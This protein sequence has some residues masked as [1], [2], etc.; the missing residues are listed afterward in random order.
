MRRVLA[1]IVLA[2]ACVQPA[3][4]AGAPPPIKPEPPPQRAVNPDVLCKRMDDLHAATCGM[5]GEIALTT[6][7]PQE[8]MGALS[9]PRSR[10]TTELMD[11]C[12]S[13][14]ER[15]SD[16]VACVGALEA[17]GEY[18]DCGDRSET[19]LADAVGVPYGTWRAEMKR[20]LVK[21][22]EVRST[23]AAPI[24]LCGVTTEN[25]WLTT[26]TCD[27]GSHP[28]AN[29]P[30]AEKS[31]AGNVGAGGRCNSIID[32]YRI[33]CPEGPYDL[34]LDGDVCPLPQQ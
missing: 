23:K 2:G 22:S 20:G 32:H 25:F 31:R 6:T 16:I 4:N 24:E 3:S 10:A 18:R 26:L 27:D 15:C 12:T 28:L 33:A 11:T 13:E 1:S 17:T 19:K 30:A 7:C 8:V 34:Y 29:R 9:D 5:F 14:L 21:L